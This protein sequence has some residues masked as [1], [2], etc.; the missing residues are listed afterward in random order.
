MTPM[1][2]RIFG[3]EGGGEALDVLMKYLYVAYSYCSKFHGEASL[4]LQ[5]IVTASLYLSTLSTGLWLTF[6]L[7]TATK[8][9]QHQAPQLARHPHV[10]QRLHHKVLAP[11]SR[12]WEDDLVRR[13]RVVDRL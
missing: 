11:G 5:R 7:V 1:L 6:M 9:W 13:M 12:R 3:S 4:N 2:Q 8:E 10:V